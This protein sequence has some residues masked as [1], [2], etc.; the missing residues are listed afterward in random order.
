[1]SNTIPS[2]FRSAAEAHK[3]QVLFRYFHDS[4]KTMTYSGFSALAEHIALHLRE[5]GLE[6][7]DRVAIISENRPEWCA[8]YLAIVMCGGIAVPID[9]QLGAGE[10][11]NLLLDSGSKLVFCSSRTEQNVAEAIGGDKIRTMSFDGDEIQPGE[12]SAGLS[13]SLRPEHSPEDIASI[14][15]TSGTTGNPKGVMLT[16]NN[17]CSDAEAV[18]SAGVVTKNDNVLSVLPLHHTYPFM[19]TFLVPLFLGATVTFSPGLKAAEMVASIK[20]NGVTV[21]VGVPRL[22]ET[23]RNGIFS[24]IKEK[25]KIA[26]ILLGLANSFSGRSIAI[27]EQSDF[28]QAAEQSSIPW[29]WKTWSPWDLPCWRATG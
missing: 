10:I 1:M 3:D 28:L 11:K 15:Y 23:I 27:S 9:M 12:A 16:H 8:G 25:G 4:W 18:M 19:C 26:A 22:F 2:L 6:K 5:K 14:I 21:V 29:L 17:F 13:H 24:K 20:E 7:D